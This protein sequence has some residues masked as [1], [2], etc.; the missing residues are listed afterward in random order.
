VSVPAGNT[1]SAPYPG[2]RPFRRDEADI[3]FGREHHVDRM[4]DRLARHRLLVVIGSSGSGKSS[5]VS[6][7]LLE[8][9]EMG[10]LAAAGPVW[11]FAILR[12]GSRPM[13]HLA[14]ALLAAGGGPGDADDI[15]LHR[16]ALERSPQSLALELQE[17]PLESGGN[18]LILVDQFE[19][20]FRLDDLAGREEAEAFVALLLSSAEQREASIYVVL[21]MRSDFIGRCAD[22]RGLAEAVSETQYLCPRLGRDELVAAIKGPI[23]VFGATT[24]PS[25]VTRLVNDMGNHP[26]QLP[27]MEHALRRLWDLA[28]HRDP[29][30]PV[31]CLADYEMVGRFGGSLSQHAEEIL[32]ELSDARERVET[33]RRLFCL[34]VEG[35]G[36]RAIR[37]P[38]L[39]TEAASVANVPVDEIIEIA[40]AFRMPGRG[41]LY[42][43]LSYPL[44][45]DTVL[46]IAHEGLIRQWERLREWTREEAETAEQYREI[47]RRAERW[48]SGS[49]SLLGGIDL[50]VALAWRG[51]VQPTAGWAARYGGD[52]SLA[53]G[54]LDEGVRHRDRRTRRRRF[55]LVAAAVGIIVALIGLG[56]ATWRGMACR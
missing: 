34:L 53:M 25:L 8:S 42:P 55:L 16:A 45:A 21:T 22:F 48:E 26:D 31:L 14:A 10:L 52:F 38:V 3:F 29:A 44:T 11:R 47:V 46:D 54:Y 2:L 24:E 33:A 36:D 5:L 9:L 39:V 28:W 32:A 12:P 6:A 56:F 37:Q 13:T 27:L 15:A 1:A 49:G 19:E 51:R 35:E 4:V 20:L 7:G 41:F 43:D 50:D 17:Y 30:A 18:L 23:E 40:D